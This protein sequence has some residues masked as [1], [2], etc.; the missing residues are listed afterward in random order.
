[1]VGHRD[2]DHGRIRRHG[3]ENLHGHVRRRPVCLGG[4]TDYRVARS[5]HRVELFDVLLTHAGLD[6]R[7][8]FHEDFPLGKTISVFKS[9]LCYSVFIVFTVDVQF[10]CIRV[11]KKKNTY[12]ST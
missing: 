7:I 11:K 8:I 10:L 2:H 3:S 1:M 6:N 4:R 9:E 12:F 5:R